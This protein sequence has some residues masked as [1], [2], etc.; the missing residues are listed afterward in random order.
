MATEPSTI[1]GVSSR[2]SACDRCRGQKLRCLRVRKKLDHNERCDRCAKADA[3]CITSPIY[4]M[5]NMFA[6]D[7][8][9]DSPALSGKRR[10]LSSSRPCVAQSTLRD[11]G[12]SSISITNCSSAIVAGSDFEYQDW[13][14]TDLSAA[15]ISNNHNNVAESNIRSSAIFSNLTSQE[16]NMISDAAP[17]SPSFNATDNDALG[18]IISQEAGSRL[19]STT[20][21]PQLGIEERLEQFEDWG[22]P[23][24]S[25]LASELQ[26]CAV[27]RDE[28][29]PNT[30]TEELSTMNLNLVKQLK[31]MALPHVNMKTLIVPDCTQSSDSSITP[32]EDIL[33]STRL[34]LEILSTIAGVPRSPR[35]SSSDALRLSM[36]YSGYL[37]THTDTLEVPYDGS[38]STYTPSAP[39]NDTRLDNTKPDSSTLLLVLVCY[40]HLLKL[41]VALF[42]HIE[43]YLHF[44]SESEERTIIPLPRLCG[45]SNFPLGKF[46][47]DG[48]QSQSIDTESTESGNLQASM[49]IQL[50]TNMFERIE[51]LLGLPSEFRLGTREDDPRGLLRD[52]VFFK[53]A[54]SVIQKENDLSPEQERGGI[55]SLR[56]D[57]EQSKH[58][59]CSRIAP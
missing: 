50:V 57:I 1:S 54:I 22:H 19:P 29:H 11:L 8:E 46:L 45:F 20:A 3:Q 18:H 43:H 4:H 34:Y 24:L 28:T 58:L 15:T 5:R 56:R 14:P 17:G 37:G 39:S 33:N 35:S 7:Q 2:R 38:S 40:I 52:E 16:W 6:Q 53:F 36:H 42:R 26:D 44:V 12:D 48:V 41:H 49:I 55:L 27:D 23:D 9:R 10:R 51:I 21:P 32:L 59:L 31:R 25:T 47:G 30:S 13:A